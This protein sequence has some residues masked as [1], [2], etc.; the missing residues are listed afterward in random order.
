[1]TALN[2]VALLLLLAVTVNTIALFL[3]LAVTLST[4]ALLVLVAV[5]GNGI[6]LWHLLLLLA[7]R[8]Q[9]TPAERIRHMLWVTKGEIRPGND[10]L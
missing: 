6:P 10:Q 7:T 5:N 8:P 2:T 1:V 4:I 3:L 9:S